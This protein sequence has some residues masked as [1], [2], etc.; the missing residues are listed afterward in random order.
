MKK[1]IK[2]THLFV[3]ISI[4]IVSCSN[5]V[6]SQQLVDFGFEKIYSVSVND[7]LGNSVKNAWAGG[8]NACQFNEIDLNLDGIKDL[9]IFDRNGNR[10]LTYLNN[11]INAQVSYDFSPE[12]T[13][14]L[15]RFDDWVIFTDY[16]NDGKNDIFTY[17]KGF[18]G[19]K[20][21]KNISE[22]SLEFQLVVYP[23]L[24]SFQ[25][26]G[27]VNI[28]VTYADYPA[29][30]DIDKDG[31]LDILTFWGLGSFV[32]MHL[33]ESMEIYGVP[34]SLIFRK[35][36]VCWGR[37]A[38]SEESNVIYL[39]TC[40]QKSLSGNSDEQR[41]TGST[42]LIFDENNDGLDDLLLGDVDYSSPALLINGGTHEE[43][44][45]ISNTFIFP[46]YNVPIDILSFPVMN[47]L[48]INND[49]KK[50]LIV[51]TFD[52]SL[53]KSRNI[54][55]VWFYKNFGENNSPVF[56]L[57]TKSLFQDEMI[58]LGAGA[59]PVIF[60]YNNDGL[61]DLVVSNFGYFDSLYYSAGLFLNC[62]YRS[63]LAL[64][65]N[66]GAT[67]EPAFKLITRDFANISQLE[68]ETPL[69]G[70]YPAFG[71]LDGDSDDD[72]LL[73]NEKGNLLY[74]ENIASTGQPADFVLNNR[75]YQNIDVGY[76]SAPQLF[77]LNEDGL[78]DLICGRRNGTLVYFENTGTQQIP[79]FTLTTDSLGKVDVRNP[80]LSIFGYAIPYFFYGN[81]G[82]IKLFVGSEFGKN[83]Y[84]KNIEENLNSAFTPG[85][86][87][88][89][90]INQG[91]RSS[92]AVGNF[93]GDNFPDMII[94]NYSGG[95]SYY[96][97]VTP[98]PA[99]YQEHHPTSFSFNIY[100]SPARDFIFIVLENTSQDN[101]ELI[102]YN[103]LGKTVLKKSIAPSNEIT[104]INISGLV[105]GIYFCR[106]QQKLKTTF[107]SI[108]SK[109]FIIQ[110]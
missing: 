30:Y 58:D 69:Q 90:W 67:N 109:K 76:Y 100:P 88:L 102:I 66:T 95:L 65:E 87:S 68:F 103:L 73:G 96:K 8:L 54:E 59:Y 84:Y 52:P 26:L 10:K 80:N 34:D 44:L 106:I 31:D 56:E 72:M 40:Y 3:L 45:M 82:K 12:Y 71:D 13:E 74:F 17:S 15:P 14:K 75:N 97:G 5:I 29:I 18:A 70:G 104:C 57:Q 83:F 63:Q 25:G 42:F 108:S 32:E 85:D 38:E 98:P 11:G 60:D 41:H 50:D 35:T 28:L 21:Y 77:D 105:N 9:L 61:M 93:N 107:G 39:D 1:I 49:D 53:I 78:T 94:G 91:L 36:V 64:F 4:L 2:K 23:Y 89:A 110:H 7:S 79:V 33:N 20:V 19:I 62:I 37:F 99:G 24:K 48:D 6:K 46:D 81:D 51:S 47:Y 86:L 22:T 27:Y 16:N 55:S 43:A 101:S 92:M